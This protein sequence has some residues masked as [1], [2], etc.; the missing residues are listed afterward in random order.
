MAK[1]LFFSLYEAVIFVETFSVALFLK[2]TSVWGRYITITPTNG[3]FNV[4]RGHMTKSARRD[5]KIRVNLVII[6][7]DKIIG[8]NCKEAFKQSLEKA[9]IILSSYFVETIISAHRKNDKTVMLLL[10]TWVLVAS[11]SQFR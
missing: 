11:V 6:P 1:E 2:N 10:Y 4:C 3:S 9:G 7:R 8:Y 5:L